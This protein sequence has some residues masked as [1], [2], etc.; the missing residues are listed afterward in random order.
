[1]GRGVSSPFGRRHSWGSPSLYGVVCFG[2]WGFFAFWVGSLV[3]FGVG[4]LFRYF[5]PEARCFLGGAILARRPWE[6]AKDEDWH[7]ATSRSP[8]P[9]L[10]QGR[11]KLHLPTS[12]IRGVFSAEFL[13]F[14]F[15]LWLF[16][17]P[18]TASL[19][20]ADAANHLSSQ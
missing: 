1:M 7:G 11:S 19:N 2:V 8:G 12:R 9:C 5:Y 16:P 15:L 3:S 14:C 4:A 6:L 10:N 20:L 17:S 18:S 13:L